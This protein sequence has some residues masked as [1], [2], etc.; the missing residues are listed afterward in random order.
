M[1]GSILVVDDSASDRLLIEHLLRGYSVLTASDGLEAMRQIDEHED[2]SL[3]ILDLNMPVM[4]G[5]EVLK[6]LRSDERYK[7]LRTII[8]TNY[9]EIENEIEGLRLGAVDY[10]RKPIHMDSLRIRVNI[11]LELIWSQQ[12]I[13]EK[14]DEQTVTLDAIFQQAPIGIAINEPSADGSRLVAINKMYEEITGRSKEELLQLGWVKITHPDDLQEDLANLKKLQSREIKSYSMEKRFIKPD[15]SIVWVFMV[16]ALLSLSH[17]EKYTNICLIKDITKRKEAEEALIESERSKSV[18][19]S[20]LPGLAYRCNYDRDWTMQFVSAGCLALTGYH[21]ESLLYNRDVP[22]NDVIAP[23]YREPLWQEWERILAARQ[24]FKYEYEIITAMGER[25][26]VL[27]IG[28]GVYNE[29]GAVEALEGIILDISDRKSIE[30]DLRYNSEHD[31]WTGLY[32]RRS[33]ENLLRCDREKGTARNRA[34][35]GINLSVAHLLTVTYG[36]N[37]TL[38]LIKKISKELDS[39]CTDKRLLFNTFENRFVFYMKDYRDKNQLIQF[40]E[41]LIELLGTLLFGERIGAGIGV[42]EINREN[43]QDIDQLLKNLLIASEK[44]M[45]AVDSD[46]AYCFFDGEMEAEIMR[47]EEIKRELDKIAADEGQGGLFLQYQPILDLKSNQICGFEALARLQSEK[48]GLVQPTEFIPIAEKTKLIIPVGRKIV[49]QAF[50]F[51]KRLK[52]N[53]HGAVSVAVNVSAIELLRNDFSSNLWDAINELQVDPENI[54]LEI[55]ES[56]F[57]SNYHDINKIIGELRQ[58]GIHIAIDDFGT[59]YSSLARERELNVN[60]LK[61]DKFFLDKLLCIDLKYAITCDVISMAHKLGHCVIAE[62]VEH[63]NQLEYLRNHGCDRVQGFLISKPLD[64]EEAL[65]MLK[66]Q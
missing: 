44:A 42:I 6:A 5:F 31:I 61:I 4:N 56:V 64:E 50:S 12:L 22:F 40:C 3:I 23:E 34:I 29:Q 53:G 10:I 52:E 37:Y 8:L 55:T 14:L 16:V 57:A 39:L 47:E 49:H 21:P 41:M 62:G 32:N 38:E 66:K 54:C 18:L 17:Y 28:E 9:N 58:A 65:E 15:G 46:F 13:Q 30:H 51:L 25:K 45:E 43:E 26:W 19:L 7:K 1:T 27:E 24:P 63:E 35:V 11:H 60:C 20:H 33:L 36:F 48:L 59:G 2:I